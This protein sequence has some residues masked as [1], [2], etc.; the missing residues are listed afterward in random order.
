MKW[1]TVI[2]ACFLIATSPGT[3]AAEEMAV[4]IDVQCAIFKKIFPY[5][6]TLAD[7]YP[8]R[9][10]VV[11]NADSSRRKDE[12]VRAFEAMAF[13][14]TASP[15]QML[16][17]RL[18]AGV[19]LYVMDGVGS[20]KKLCRQKSILAITGYPS[21]VESGEAAVGVGM[22]ARRPTILVHNGQMKAVGHNLSFKLL[23]LATVYE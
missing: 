10:V 23:Q 7:Y 6:R 13:S 20:V 11:Y 19:V 18:E 12:V 16:A 17:D 1:K 4:P 8:P 5:V 15:E 3:L 9:I 14:A 2:L 22:D 21:L